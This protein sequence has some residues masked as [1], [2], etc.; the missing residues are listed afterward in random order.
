MTLSGFFSRV[1]RNIRI[2]NKK[3][4]IEEHLEKKE[5]LIYLIKHLKNIT[6]KRHQV[7]TLKQI[8]NLNPY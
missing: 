6:I 5:T 2:K 3:P 8:K 1:K 7:V 4:R